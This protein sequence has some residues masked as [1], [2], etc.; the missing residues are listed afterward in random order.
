MQHLDEETAILHHYGEDEG[1]GDVE[2][3]LESCQACHDLYRRLVEDL[4]RIDALPVPDPGAGYPAHLWLRLRPQLLAEPRVVVPLRRRR[5]LPIAAAA[6]LVTIGFLAGAYW[7]SS[8]NTTTAAKAEAAQRVYL[9]AVSQHLG[10][11]QVLLLEV[12][13]SPDDESTALA[14]DARRAADLVADNRIY[15]LTA[16]ERSDP[17]VASL[18]EELERVLLEIANDSETLAPED[19]NALRQRIDSQSLLF[20][21]RAVGA[22]LDQELRNSGALNL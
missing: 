5:W 6:A 4:E 3:H 7:H 2:A 12:S 10:R 13:N 11:A 16:S 8:R 17:R 15:R 20:K 18:L 21:A 19:I 22:T 1:S 14:G 9:A